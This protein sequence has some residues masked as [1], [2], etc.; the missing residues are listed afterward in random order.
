MPVSLCGCLC[1][2]VSTCVFSV[3]M[4]MID[5]NVFDVVFKEKLSVSIDASPV[6]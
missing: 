2:C 1:A 5:S 6:Y 3:F 4:E